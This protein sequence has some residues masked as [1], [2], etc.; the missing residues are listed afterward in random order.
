VK[1][2]RSERKIDGKDEEKNKAKDLFVC[3]LEAD[4]GKF[5]F[6]KSNSGW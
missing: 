1:V 6:R 5:D 2:L 3:L 4:V